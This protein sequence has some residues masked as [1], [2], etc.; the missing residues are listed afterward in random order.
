MD[1]MGQTTYNTHVKQKLNSSSSN[2]EMCSLRKGTKINNES[3]ESF[4]SL[5]GRKIEKQRRLMIRCSKGVKQ[6]KQKKTKRKR[7][8]GRNGE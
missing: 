6:K 3:L 8:K 1:K 2:A 4:C 5:I 7:K